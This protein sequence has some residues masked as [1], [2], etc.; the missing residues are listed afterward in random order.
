MR[1]YHLKRAERNLA[2]TMGVKMLGQSVMSRV[3]IVFYV[4]EFCLA[5]TQ[6]RTGLEV[7]YWLECGKLSGIG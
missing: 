6:W 4:C 7:L 5:Y 3:E 1:L 2:G